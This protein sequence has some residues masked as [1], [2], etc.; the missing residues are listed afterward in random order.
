M[1]CADDAA[2]TVRR[3]IARL[4]LAAAAAA[5][6][7]HAAGTASVITGTGIC[8]SD[9]FLK[10]LEARTGVGAERGARG[11]DGVELNVHGDAPTARSH[12]T[13]V[14]L[15]REMGV[16]W[17][18]DR[19]AACDVTIVHVTPAWALAWCEIVPTHF[20]GVA[21]DLAF[22]EAACIRDAT[23]DALAGFEAEDDA[24]ALKARLRGVAMTA[25]VRVR[26][27]ALSS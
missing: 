16:D 15:V 4:H 10:E 6:G 26:R 17:S 19:G 22:D 13:A 20:S 7:A 23:D 8:F 5:S 9:A 2:S 24:R 11:G 27:E 1:S 18:F 3:R 12:P 21:D 25:S 14:A